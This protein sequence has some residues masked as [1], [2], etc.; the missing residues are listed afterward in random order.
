MWSGWLAADAK[1]SW[2]EMQSDA[3]VEKGKQEPDLGA[4]SQSQLH[5]FTAIITGSKSTASGK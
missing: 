2:E 4:R 1:D 3:I 5:Y